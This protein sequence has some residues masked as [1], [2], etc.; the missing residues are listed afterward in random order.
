MSSA[1]LYLQRRVD[2]S[3]IEKNTCAIGM[4]CEC[5]ETLNHNYMK[6]IERIAAHVRSRVRTLLLDLPR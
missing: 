4:P 5:K 2:K 6:N 1:I 3:S